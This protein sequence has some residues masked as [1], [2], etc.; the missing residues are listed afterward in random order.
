M[1]QCYNSIVINAGIEDVWQTVRDF[2]QMDWAAPVI[3]SLDKVGVFTGNE[4]GAR[5]ILNNAFHETL[6]SV[7]EKNHRFTYS[8]DD[9]PG[10]VASDVVDDYV[11][12][13]ALLPVT[14]SGE[15]YA[16]WTSTYVSDDEA[17]VAALCNPIYSALLQ[18]LKTYME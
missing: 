18:A 17:A 13:L 15:T 5:R 10:P 7:D 3:T 4:Y 9:G 6:M 16:E 14:A 11:G 2:H 8:I 1:G 12:R